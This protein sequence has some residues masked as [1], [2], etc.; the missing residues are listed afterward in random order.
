[1]FGKTIL[2]LVMA[3][4]ATSNNQLT[5][6]QKIDYAFSLLND[7]AG[8]FTEDAGDETPNCFENFRDDAI[9]ACDDVYRKYFEETLYQTCDDET[10]IK[11]DLIK[12]KKVLN[13]RLKCDEIIKKCIEP[14]EI[15][16][17]HI[18]DLF[19]V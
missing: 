3:V 10:R 14:V 15:P 19:N 18:M 13:Q 8:C 9:T 11:V 6:T 12:H 5:D 16:T 2:S 7:T 17:E 4:N 1:M